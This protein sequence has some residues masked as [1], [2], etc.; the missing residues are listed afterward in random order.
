MRGTVTRSVSDQEDLLLIFD[1]A[2]TLQA[3]VVHGPGIDQ[4]LLLLPDADRDGALAHGEPTRRLLTDGLGSITAVVDDRS[5]TL[6]ERY[7]YESFG[8]LTLRAPD[9]TVLPHSAVGNPYGFTGREVDA[10]SGL[11]YYR[12]R[13]YDPKIGRFLQE[14]LMGLAGGDINLYRYVFNNAV[15]L[16]DPFGEAC[17]SM[18]GEI[19]EEGCVVAGGGVGGGV[20]RG[21][22]GGGLRGAGPRTGGGRTAGQGTATSCPIPGGR[23]TPGTSGTKLAQRIEKAGWVRRP[24]RNGRGYIYTDPETGTEVRIMTRPDGTAYSRI[25]NKAGNYLTADGQHPAPGLTRQQAGDLTHIE[26]QP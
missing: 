11:Y 23:I 1:G 18:G 9:G 20:L 15:N 24:T 21:G 6:V 12:S 14:D 5:G 10:E 26:L 17:F 4:P 16:V 25:K 7:L 8:T 13:Y 2:N 22:G 3:G 19:F